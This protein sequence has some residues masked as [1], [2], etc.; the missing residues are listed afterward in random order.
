M[1][2]EEIELEKGISLDVVKNISEIK[3]EPNWMKE[4]RMESYKF[5]EKCMMPSFGPELNIDFNNIT[6]YKR[7]SNKSF[8]N[9]ESVRCDVKNTFDNIGLID[10]EKKYLGG[11]AA[12][13]ES[14]VIYHNMIKEL[15]EKINKLEEKK[16]DYR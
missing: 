6:Y 8:N 1:L 16:Q 7:I 3:G 13:Y 14:E 12:Q 2:N 9:W 5:F 11:A 10:A 4:F 15:E